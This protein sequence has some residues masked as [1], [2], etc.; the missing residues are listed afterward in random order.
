MV[1]MKYTR[2]SVIERWRHAVGISY[3]I[4][5]YIYINSANY[6]ALCVQ[7]DFNKHTDISQV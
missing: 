6:Y 5:I 2:K 7:V 4:Y 1:V 3:T